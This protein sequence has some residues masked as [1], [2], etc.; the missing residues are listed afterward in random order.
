MS[1]S[2]WRAPN[3]SSSQ[4]AISEPAVVLPKGMRRSCDTGGKPMVTG[5]GKGSATSGF[6]FKGR[7][8]V[9]R[10]REAPAAP[11]TVGK[12]ADSAMP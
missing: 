2:A 10:V 5:M 6:T 3:R 1:A 7:W 4:V 9:C 11:S 12:K 8:E